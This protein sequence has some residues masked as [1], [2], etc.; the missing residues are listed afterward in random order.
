MAEFKFGVIGQERKALVTA[1]SEILQTKA[2]YMKT[3]TYAY[4]IGNINIDKNGTGTGEF[5]TDLLEELAERGF[6]AEIEEIEE[7]GGPEMEE[8]AEPEIESQEEPEEAGQIDTISITL[9]LDGFTPEAIDN[10]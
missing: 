2:V 10:L 6:Q 4:T 3:P 9:P 1:I 5:S 8:N 7:N